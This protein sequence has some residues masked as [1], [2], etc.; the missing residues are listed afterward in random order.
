MSAALL[1]APAVDPTR[2]GGAGWKRVALA[3][4]LLAWG[5]NHFTP[6]L[7]MYEVRG[8][9]AS[10]QANLL[11]GTYVAGLVPGL[12]IAS[13]ISD[14]HGRK[15]VLFG[16]TLLAI[17]GSVLLGAGFDS[18]W[19]LCVGRAF[20][21]IGVGVAMSVGTSWIKE[22]SS[23]PYDEH[24]SGSAGARRPSLALTGGFALG[25]LVTG[26]LAQWGPAPQVTP[27]A[28]HIALSVVALAVLARAPESLPVASRTDKSWWQDLRIPSTGHRRF[29]RL[30]L[31][32]APWVFGA[33]GVAYAIMPAVVQSGLGDQAT[34]YA[35][36]LT[37]LTLGTG[38]LAQNAVS[39]INRRTGGRALVVGLAAMAAGL[40]LAVIAAELANPVIAV[41]VAIAL[42]AA[43]GICLVA[44]LIHV[45]AIATPQDLAGLTGVYYSLTY[46]GFLLPAAL[47][48]LLPLVSYGPSLIAVSLIC[49]GCLLV[50]IRESSR[51]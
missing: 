32:A 35:T 49:L 5:G 36:A 47:A 42:G 43:Y 8:G 13:A 15:P 31:P 9:Y 24:S 4:F 10:W 50:V 48:A 18:Y 27:Y 25:A 38:A 41:F 21:G 26:L 33:A 19:L 7:H 11:L 40:A 22:L 17:G 16:G 3:V 23:P 2:A 39:A 1:Q 6:L 46:T 44:G 45:Q 51:H 20:A 14:R 30:V 28:V 12:L 29:T 34:L 37:V